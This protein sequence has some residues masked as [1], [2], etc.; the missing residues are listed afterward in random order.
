MKYR[1]DYIA[2]S[3]SCESGYNRYYL[4][5][6]PLAMASCAK[7]QFSAS[8]SIAA[9]GAGP[10]RCGGLLNFNVCLRCPRNCKFTSSHIPTSLVCISIPPLQLLNMELASQKQ[11]RN[12]AMLWPLLILSYVVLVTS[13][14]PPSTSDDILDDVTWRD[15]PPEMLRQQSRQLISLYNNPES[16]GPGKID[17]S[18]PEKRALSVLS[19]WKPFSMGFS[20][21]VGRYPPRAPLLSMV[22]E[23]D[24]VS[25]ETRG[26][27]RPIG[28]PLRWGRR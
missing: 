4:K 28:Q 7:K 20:N 5:E 14:P 9:H 10:L 22:P 23:L 11:K 25:A 8:S 27:L 21:L 18:R 3:S 12:C 16:P 15:L 2:Y 1:S 6:A 13:R 17:I 19:R 26:T 24:F